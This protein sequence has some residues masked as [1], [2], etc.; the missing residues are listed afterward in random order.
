MRVD[1]NY[2]Q[3]VFSLNK[4]N[5]KPAMLKKVKVEEEEE[6]IIVWA[7]QICDSKPNEAGEL[8]KATRYKAIAY[9]QEN[10]E[11][12]HVKIYYFCGEQIEHSFELGEEVA[13]DLHLRKAGQ[14]LYLGA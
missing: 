10:T 12:A 6:P 9:Q 7:T 8:P 1:S 3:Q 14:I 13:E 5:A 2:A 11:L 4:Y